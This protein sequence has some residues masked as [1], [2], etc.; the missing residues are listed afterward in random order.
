MATTDWTALRFLASVALERTNE[1]MASMKVFD[2]RDAVSGHADAEECGV[3]P[4]FFLFEL[5]LMHW[6][7]GCIPQARQ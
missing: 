1:Q 6:H 4:H 7:P 2:E 5:Y 3:R